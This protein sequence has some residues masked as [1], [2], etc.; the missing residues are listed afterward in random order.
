MNR[1]PSHIIHIATPVRS[2]GQ[3]EFRLLSIGHKVIDVK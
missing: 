1:W 2:C 3:F